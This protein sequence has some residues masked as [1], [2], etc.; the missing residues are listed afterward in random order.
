MIT[1]S[2]SDI[3]EITI[4]RSEGTAISENILKQLKDE[5]KTLNLT[6]GIITWTIEPEKI[7][8]ETQKISSTQISLTQKAPERVEKVEELAKELENV[9]Y[10]NV[11]VQLLSHV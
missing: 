1:G 4:D 3:V 9:K 8:D 7:T 10:L 5:E 6:D 2:D 11:E